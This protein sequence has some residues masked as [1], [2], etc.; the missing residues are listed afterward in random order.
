MAKKKT[1]KSPNPGKPNMR[2]VRKAARAHREGCAAI[3]HFLYEYSQLEFTIK[4]V[5]HDRLKLDE[6]FFDI[7]IGPYD[8]RMLCA[9][10]SRV[11]CIRYP[12][13]AEAI[14]KLYNEI[15]GFNTERVNIA[16]GTWTDGLEG[17]SLRVFNRQKLDASYKDYTAA[18][19]LALG[20][21]AQS[22]MQRVMGFHGQS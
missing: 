7:V 6:E 13:K 1:A 19:L 18:D 9:V 21:K 3:G 16:H 11:S 10:T 22:L 17:F 14:K 15:Q 4:A 5:L 12:E 2:L 20:Q 8:F